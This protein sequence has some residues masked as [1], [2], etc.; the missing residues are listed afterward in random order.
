M[1][2]RITF[3]TPRRSAKTVSDE[4]FR[5]GA[6]SVDHSVSGASCVISALAE[7]TAVEN[8][9]SR[10][11][12]WSPVKEALPEKDWVNEWAASFEGAEVAPGIFVRPSGSSSADDPSCMV[13]FIDPRDAFGAGSHPTTR[14]CCRMLADAIALHKPSSFLDAGTGTGILA[15]LASRLGVVTSEGF[16]IDPLSAVRAAEN[17]EAN[18]CSSVRFSVS[19][20]D[21]FSGRGYDCVCANVNSAVIEEYFDSIAGFLSA[22]GVLLLSGIGSEWRNAMEDLFLSKSFLVEGCT[23]EEGW[24]GY[25][26]ERKKQV[27]PGSR[28]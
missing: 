14:I 22:S 6:M 11:A 18:G 7:D 20:I 24:L 26:L 3:K 12:D 2:Y 19:G 28:S 9:L 10:Y 17:A 8:V 1:I 5:L 27:S 4:L 15:I 23:E 13:L 21:T 25:V 16:D